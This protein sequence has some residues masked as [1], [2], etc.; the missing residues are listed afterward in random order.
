MGGLQPP[1][2]RG[3]GGG[4]RS[5]PPPPPPRASSPAPPWAPSPREAIQL[6]RELAARVVSSPPDGFA[7][8]IVAGVDAAFPRAA[9]GRAR[10]VVA[11]AV[12]WDLRER[13]VVETRTIRRPLSF[14]YVPGL[15][16]FREAPAALEALTSL[17]TPVDAV[18]T[19]G[20]GLAHPRRFGLA[21]HLGVLTGLPT[22]GCAKSVL[23]GDFDPPGLERGSRTLLVHREETVGAVVRTRARVSPVFV[24]VGHRLDLEAAVRLVLAAGAG[25]RLPEPTRRADRA[26]AAARRDPASLL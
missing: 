11:A 18:I 20:H 3:G 25:F 16:S 15:L 19:D 23:V 8:R 22:A 14:P 6:Q 4:G 26:C 12:A 1:P 5:P 13:A 24:S 9:G 2:P 21:C 7:P 17:E 10:D